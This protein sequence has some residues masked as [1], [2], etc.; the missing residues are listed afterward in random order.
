M[1]AR[2][3]LL[4]ANV[5]VALADEHH[6][7][8][9]RAL[10]W[11]RT[12]PGEWGTCAFTEAAFLRIT[13]N[14]ATGVLNMTEAIEVLTSLLNEPGYRFWPITANW[15]TVAAPFLK[16][17]FGHKQITD[18]YLLGLAIQE[19]GVLVTLDR[20]IRHMAGERYAGN[21]LVLE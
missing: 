18:A 1:S 3:Y 12:S 11:F 5:L 13:T 6:V 9:R 4:D 8:H 2:A 19:K 15:T 21:V 14:P 7:H 20:G 10:T 16:R 17:I